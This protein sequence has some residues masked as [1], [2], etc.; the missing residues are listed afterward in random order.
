MNTLHK[1]LSLGIV[2]VLLLTASLWFGYQ[3]FVAEGSVITGG[4]YRATQITAAGTTTA[5]TLFGSIGSVVLT[6]S[7]GA[8]GVLSF[9]ASTT[10]NA[11]SSEDL[12]FTFDGTAIE[13]TYQYDVAFPHGLLIQASGDWDGDAVITVR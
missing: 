11:T 12:L 10:N 9:F 1:T 7:S 6:S 5:R 3:T 4:E 2:V 13:G 8:G